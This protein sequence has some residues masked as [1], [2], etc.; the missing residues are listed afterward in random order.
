MST[1]TKHIHEVLFMMIE[2]GASYNS[3]KELL[4]EVEQ[5]FGKDVSFYSCSQ[6]GIKDEGIIDF[7]KFKNKII[8]T[9]DGAIILKDELNMCDGHH[10]H[11]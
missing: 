7:L 6:Q 9:E 11:H 10:H 4:E 1:N 3:S 2:R 5:K 8:I